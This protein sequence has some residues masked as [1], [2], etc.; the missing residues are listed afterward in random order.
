MQQ[1]P[2]AKD[3]AEVLGAGG[4]G[5]VVKNADG[6][7]LKLFYESTTDPH[8]EAA[9]QTKARELLAAAGVPI[10]VA[11][12]HSVTTQPLVW[13]SQ[14]L[15]NGI[16]MEAVEAPDGGPQ[17]H[18][19]L[20]Y[21]GADLDTLWLRDS[22][23]PA[24]PTNL[25]RGFFA[26][27]DTLTE[28]WE[29]RGSRWTVERVARLMGRAL[30][31]LIAGGIVPVDLEFVYGD[32][33]AIWL[34]DFGLCR[35]GRVDPRAFLTARGSEGL[36]GEIYIPQEGWRGRAEFLESY[37]RGIRLYSD[38][39]YYWTLNM[40]SLTATRDLYRL[41]NYWKKIPNVCAKIEA[42]I[43]AGAQLSNIH[44]S[45]GPPLLRAISIKC[46]LEIIKLLAAYCPIDFTYRGFHQSG[47][48]YV[49]RDETQ[50]MENMRSL[51]D[52]DCVVYYSYMN[53]L[54]TIYHAA[55]GSSAVENK[56]ITELM[57]RGIIPSDYSI[58]I[59][60]NEGFPTNLAYVE[61]VCQILNINT[62]NLIHLDLY[63]VP[64]VMDDFE[65]LID[66]EDDFNSE[67]RLE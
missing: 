62:D 57:V 31:V 52:I 25:P 24:G 30:A 36:A 34:I 33:D 66:H 20:G 13:R 37:Y 61:E 18:I 49:S 54:I 51:F 41:I 27:A 40:N 28:L 26:G 5:V 56:I 58:Y 43:S 14:Q 47:V 63:E 35:F 1:P 32:D 11:A 67:L 7:A 50:L 8:T 55:I 22:A 48:Y 21:A 44:T 9:I 60:N 12:V 64:Y 17:M 10:K 42:C 38:G 4:Y 3:S 16:T 45:Y 65:Q 6:H 29:E 15:L 59:P 2:P 39:T 53:E 46:D 23:A 19:L